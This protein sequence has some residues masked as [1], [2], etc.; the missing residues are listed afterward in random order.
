MELGAAAGGIR[1]RRARLD[2]D[3]G[4]GK[5][6]AVHL[7]AIQGEAA[8]GA[9]GQG[10]RRPGAAALIR[11]GASRG[12][13]RRFVKGG[14][15][16]LAVLVEEAWGRGGQGQRSR[17]EQTSRDVAGEKT[18]EDWGILGAGA[19]GA[20]TRGPTCGRPEAFCGM[21]PTK[22]GCEARS[23]LPNLARLRGLICM[24]WAVPR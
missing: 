6:T 9:A 22:L 20:S 5:A 7:G 1:G 15:P 19:S 21:D 8:K 14:R 11:R 17:G 16:C 18:R 24:S 2:A 12:G 13:R 4:L 23:E 10:R 3:Q